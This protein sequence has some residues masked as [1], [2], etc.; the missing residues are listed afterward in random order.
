MKRLIL[1]SVT[2]TLALS[3]CN[4]V[5]P[6]AAPQGI[7]A[8]GLSTQ[9]QLVTFGTDNA[10]AS[11]AR[12]NVSGLPSGETLVDLDVRNTDNQLYAISSAGKVYRLELANRAATATPDNSA[13]TGVAP[14]TIDFNPFANRL[15]LFGEGDRNFRLTLNAVPVSPPPAPVAGTLT[16]DGTL[17]YATGGANP[18]LVAA[19]YTQSFDNSG[20]GSLNSG[21]PNPA[22]YSID[23]DKDALVLHS[24][25]PQFNTL[26]VV[27]SLG[28]DAMKGMTGFDIAGA[29]A[30]YLS[31]STGG[32]TMLYTVNLTTGAATMKSTIT[33]L[34]LKSFALSLAAQ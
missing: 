10:A 23:A 9:G 15:R 19:A 13:L 17:A 1:I 25:A 33:G 34:A 27:G 8:Y 21:T 29:D 30:A 16:D 7:T 5:L 12:M 6:P 14:V 22:L 24:V 26:T 18:D 2:G 32:N 4:T 31:V 3:A 11:A 28:V 20:T